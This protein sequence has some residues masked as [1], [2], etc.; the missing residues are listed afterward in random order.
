M[1]TFLVVGVVVGVVAWAAPARAQ[2]AN[3]SLGVSA[4]YL[5]VGGDLGSGVGFDRALPL[6]FEATSY[7]DS[8][9]EFHARVPVMVVRERLSGRDALATGASA[10]VRYLLSEERVRPWVGVDVGGLL[11]FAPAGARGLAGPGATLGL[12][13]FV[14]E[15]V[16]L[17]VRGL[18]NL[19]L[20]LNAPPLL[21]VGA[22]G[23]V[24]VSFD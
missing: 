11:L 24:A 17:G 13:V 16:S 8:G 10:G 1:R 6:F 22:T 14:S 19:F 23:G 2:F 3:R 5:Q 18:G 12:D 20:G 15:S 9:W 4:G 7:L 21:A